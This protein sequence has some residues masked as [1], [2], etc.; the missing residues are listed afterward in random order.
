MTYSVMNRPLNGSAPHVPLFADGIFSPPEGVDGASLLTYEESHFRETSGIRIYGAPNAMPHDLVTYIPPDRH[1]V[2]VLRSSIDESQPRALW[3]QVRHSTTVFSDLWAQLVARP[4]PFSQ[5]AVMS[6][7]VTAPVDDEVGWT[8]GA[9]LTS[10]TDLE[11]TPEWL[12][13]AYRL[14]TRPAKVDEPLT[15]DLD[16]YPIA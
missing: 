7:T 3:S 14:V 10:D 4:Q 1:V 13:K 16:D 8:A 6:A 11:L 9:Q 15:C 5:N 2:I 12:S